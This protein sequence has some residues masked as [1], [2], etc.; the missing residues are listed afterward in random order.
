MLMLFTNVFRERIKERVREI[1]KDPNRSI[2][3]HTP[4]VQS[5]NSR[6]VVVTSDILKAW[7]KFSGIS[8]VQWTFTYVFFVYSINKS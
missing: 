2:W 8:Y 7:I 1:E 5:L 4:V 6:R 3:V